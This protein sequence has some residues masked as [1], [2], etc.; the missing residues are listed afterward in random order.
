MP[1]NYIKL[2]VLS[3]ILFL[4]IVVVKVCADNIFEAFLPLDIKKIHK[5]IKEHP[6]QIHARDK[7]GRHRF[8]SPPES[9]S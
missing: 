2:T 5:I 4:I 7:Y 9:A 1:K 8:I 3:V 6:E